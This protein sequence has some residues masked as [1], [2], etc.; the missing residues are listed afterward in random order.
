[1]E[2]K[3]ALGFICLGLYFCMAAFVLG[4]VIG[5]MGG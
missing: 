5:C 2:T 3:T 4:F 1:M